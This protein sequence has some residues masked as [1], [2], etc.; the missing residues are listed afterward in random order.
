MRGAA[1]G[2]FT[3]LVSHPVTWMLYWTM[4]FLTQELPGE[5]PDL[6]AI[7]TFAL[8]YSFFS[9][10]AFGIFT[11]PVTTLAGAVVGYL[12]SEGRPLDQSDADPDE[13]SDDPT[14]AE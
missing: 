12:L 13:Q 4:A 3:G 8:F 5:R 6:S 9:L 2:F 10:A 14:D 1:A 11:V 7:L